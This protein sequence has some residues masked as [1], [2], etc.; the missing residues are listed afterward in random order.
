MLKFL[1]RGWKDKLWLILGTEKK[2]YRSPI[3][4]RICIQNVLGTL[5]SIV[6]IPKIQIENWQRA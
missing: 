6:R 2:Y 4:Q 3:Q 5:N 1:L